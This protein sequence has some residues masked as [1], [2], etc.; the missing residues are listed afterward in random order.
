MA[1]Y[2]YQPVEREFI[3]EDEKT[4]TDSVFEAANFPSRE[5]A[6]DAASQLLG[7][8]HGAFVFDDGIES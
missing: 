1:F 2:V 6:E 4:W 3:A 5:A 8:A 7:D